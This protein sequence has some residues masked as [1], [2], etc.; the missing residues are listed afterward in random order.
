MFPF[1][2]NN[3]ALSYTDKMYPILMVKY[4]QLHFYKRTVCFSDCDL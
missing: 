2:D 3:K 4:N 1:H